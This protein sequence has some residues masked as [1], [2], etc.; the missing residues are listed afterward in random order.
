LRKKQH[1]VHV[2]IKFPHTGFRLASQFRGEDIDSVMRRAKREAK[3]W[4]APHL[5]VQEV[6]VREVKKATKGLTKILRGK[7]VG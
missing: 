7:V 1:V 5:N 3:K 4:E 2:Q 6:R